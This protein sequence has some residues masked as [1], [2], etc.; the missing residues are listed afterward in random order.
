LATRCCSVKS[1]VEATKTVIFT[2]ASIFSEIAERGL[3]WAR[4]LTAQMFRRLLAV[5]RCRRRGRAAR[6]HSQLAVLERQLAGGHTAGCRLR[7]ERHIVRG[8][9]GGGRQGDAEIRLS[10]FSIV[11]AIGLFPISQFGPWS[12][13]VGSGNCYFCLASATTFFMVDQLCR[14]CLTAARPHDLE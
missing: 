3:A 1:G 4:M 10:R 7:S 2:I 14:H 13:Q 5:R 11:S 9:R 12:C 6:W 8:R